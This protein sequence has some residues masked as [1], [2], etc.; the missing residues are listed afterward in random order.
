MLLSQSHAQSKPSLL[1]GFPPVPY[2]LRAAVL[3]ACSMMPASAANLAAV[4]APIRFEANVGQAPGGTDFVARG[5]GYGLA[6]KSGEVS[7]QMRRRT[8]PKSGKPV[9]TSL[10]M[11]LLGSQPGRPEPLDVLPTLSNYFIGKNPAKW[12]TGVKNYARVAYRGVYPGIDVIYYGQDGR[13]EYDFVVA[14]GVDVGS[15]VLSFDAL[16]SLTLDDKGNLSV[17]TSGNEFLQPPPSIY[18]QSGSTKVPVDGGYRLLPGNRVGFEARNYDAAREL[19]IDPTLNYSTYVG[20]SG[21]DEGVGFAVD[22]AGNAYVAGWTTS[23]NFPVTAAAYQPNLAGGGTF[24][25]VFIFKMNASGTGLAYSTY[26]GGSGDDLG[27]SVAVDSSGNAYIT[28]YTGSPDFPTTAG[29]LRTNLPSGRSAFVAKLN[30]TGTAL[31]YSTYLGG[32]VEER[33]YGIAVDGTGA[34]YVAGFSKSPD[35]PTTAGAFQ[36]SNPGAS[37]AFVTKLNSSGSGLVYSTLVGGSGED[38]ANSIALDSTGAAYLGGY[39]QSSNFPTTAG[40]FRTVFGSGL[41][42]AFATKVNNTGTG[43]VYSTF[44]GSSGEDFARAIAV[45][46][47][48][49][50]YVGGRAGA[51]DFPVTAGAFQT[52][53]RGANDSFVAKLNNSGSALVYSTFLGGSDNDQVEGLAVDSSGI[54]VA[55]GLTYSADF[56]V[57]SDAFQSTPRGAETGYVAKINAAGSGL[58]FS[59]YMGG[60]GGTDLVIAAALDASANTYVMGFTN[61]FDLVTTAGAFQRTFGGGTGNVFLAKI[62][63]DCGYSISPTTQSVTSAGGAVNVAVTTGSGCSWSSTSNA[64]W[65]SVTSGSGV[66]NGTS[67]LSVAANSGAA[68]SGTVTI[69]GQTFTV[70]QAAA[71]VSYTISS[72]PTGRTMVV[73][74]VTYTTPKTFSWPVGSTHTVTV[75]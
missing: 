42:H 37:S 11:S 48:G 60:S 57:T 63:Y 14:P 29:A 16:D 75:R 12:Q 68:R 23:G 26:L 32:A 27:W 66:G 51:G 13:L 36:T 25:D 55:V 6:L 18:Q 17:R 58:V 65:I 49:N 24:G 44:L 45:D 70:N 20:G 53:Y 15:I 3:F 73:D 39:T 31:I 56:P 69:A 4:S 71:S 34:A 62:V 50:A 67:S 7:L 1:T 38:W 74:S 10:R 40:A 43:L 41:G 33:G 59:T 35:F 19:I 61:S 52:V 21:W 9:E 47:S 54:V 64:T 28:G 5:L 30:S 2:I 46:A 22:S 8:T 72:S